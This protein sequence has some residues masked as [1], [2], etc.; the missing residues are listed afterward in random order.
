MPLFFLFLGFRTALHHGVIG[1]S[2]LAAMG[3]GLSISYFPPHPP[4]QSMALV[5]CTSQSPAKLAWATQSRESPPLEHFRA[6]LSQMN[7]GRL[8]PLRRSSI[9]TPDFTLQV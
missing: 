4:L 8:Y 5:P 2:I 9:C 1:G 6:Q 7:T 3:L